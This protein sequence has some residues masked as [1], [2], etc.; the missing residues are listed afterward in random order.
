MLNAFGMICERV[1]SHNGPASTR[2]EHGG[3]T[4]SLN[5]TQVFPLTY[6]ISYG[7]RGCVSWSA[8][9]IVP[10]IMYSTSPPSVFI[11]DGFYLDFIHVYPIR[12][13]VIITTKIFSSSKTFWLYFSVA[14]GYGHFAE[15]EIS[16]EESLA[17]VRVFFKILKPNN[18]WKQESTTIMDSWWKTICSVNCTHSYYWVGK[19]LNVVAR[20][21]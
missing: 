18:A 9:W 12:I 1:R 15:N 13:A 10:L 20:A 17:I 21:Q 7:K 14:L 19:R 4:P 3:R 6:H 11:H 8:V 2:L 5:A 16:A